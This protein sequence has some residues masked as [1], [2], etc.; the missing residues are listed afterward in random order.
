MDK[1]HCLVSF[2]TS[3]SEAYIDVSLLRHAPIETGLFQNFRCVTRRYCCCL[4]SNVSPQDAWDECRKTFGPQNVLIVS[5]SAGSHLD[6]G[7][8]QVLY[9]VID[10]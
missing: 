4:Q 1:D 3:F 6:G 10:I 7:E 5:N 2:A 9:L 8:I